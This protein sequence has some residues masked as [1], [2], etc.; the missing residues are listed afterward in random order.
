MSVETRT[1]ETRSTGQAVLRGLL[2]KC[3]HCGKGGL[4]RGYLKVVDHCDKC[5]EQLN[6]HRADDFPPYV[7]IMIIGHLLVAVMLHMELAWHVNPMTYL[8]TMVPL[9]ILLP[10]AILPSTKG[11]IVGFQWAHRMH[12][13]GI[14]NH[15]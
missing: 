5:G 4:F 14:G 9:A 10:L 15:G 2:C 3:P 8:Y 12:G 7:A 11:A 13:F 6:L 1:V